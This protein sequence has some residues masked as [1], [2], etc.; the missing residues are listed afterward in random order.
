MRDP[1]IASKMND[2]T[3]YPEH[4]RPEELTQRMRADYDK[5][6]KLFRQYNVSLD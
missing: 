2:L 4:K 3:L 5:I 6:G 1:A